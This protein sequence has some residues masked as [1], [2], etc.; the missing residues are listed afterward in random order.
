MRILIII[1]LIYSS[2][3]VFS[4]SPIAEYKLDCSFQEDKGIYNSLTSNSS[5]DCTCGVENDAIRIQGGDQLTADTLISEILESDFAISFYFQPIL[6]SNSMELISIGN[7][8]SS[9]SLLRV[10]YLTS[11]NEIV[12]EVSETVQESATLRA[13]VPP[14]KCWNQV[15]ISRK[16]NDFFLYIN[17]S[18]EDE[19]KMNSNVRFNSKEPVVIGDGPCVGVISNTYDGLIDELMFFDEHLQ[20]FRVAQ[21][22]R[23]N[24]E[25]ITNDTTIFLGDVIELEAIQN[26]GPSISWLPATG[27]SNTTSLKTNL[28]GIASQEY[29]AVFAG[30]YCVTTDTISI[31]VVD[32]NEVKCEDLLLPNVFT[33]NGDG[34]NDEFGILNGFIVEELNY[35]QIFDRWGE[36][37][38][39]TSNKTEKWDGSFKNTSVNSNMYLYKIS[40]QC[41]GSEYVKT[42]NVSVLR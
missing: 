8:C 1:C 6:N 22:Y 16:S 37:I 31:F 25:I 20:P 27:I 21:L 3:I 39:S 10:F 33:P 4:Q 9:D 11:M 2:T 29:V 32:P 41:G 5:I 19:V 12:F 38:F 23:A 42:G 40:Y 34:L 35:F 14:N 7:N 13:N 17:G 24:D 36:I 30:E 15:V 28:E 18:L 26:C